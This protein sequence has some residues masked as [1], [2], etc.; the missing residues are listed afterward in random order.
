MARQDYPQ[1]THQLSL[2]I[3]GSFLKPGWRDYIKERGFHSHVNFSHMESSNI[4]YRQ[5]DLC[6]DLP[7]S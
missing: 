1:L 6:Y 3:R 4:Q 2:T 5:L 7:M